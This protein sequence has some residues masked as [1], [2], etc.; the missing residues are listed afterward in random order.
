MEQES[1]LDFPIPNEIIMIVTAYLSTEDLLN[2]AA[3]ASERLKKCAFEVL[4]GI[5]T[6]WLK[7]NSF[8]FVEF[9]L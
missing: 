1:S 7:M 4:R 5:G 8:D 9:N 6:E 2:L 3:V